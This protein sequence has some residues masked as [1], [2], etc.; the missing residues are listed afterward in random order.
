MNDNL[1]SFHALHRALRIGH[2]I[3]IPTWATMQSSREDAH[4]D[5]YTIDDVNWTECPTSISLR[6]KKF[7]AIYPTSIK[8]SALIK[9]LG[10]KLVIKGI[11]RK[12][13]I[14]W[15]DRLSLQNLFVT[16]YVYAIPTKDK[17]DVPNA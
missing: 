6:I 12:F 5:D 3:S 11:D 17:Q 10:G 7:N 16:T 9:K 15:D 8:L 14:I 13:T 2:V 1:G 4:V